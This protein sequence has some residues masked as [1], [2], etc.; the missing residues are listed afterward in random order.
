MIAAAKFPDKKCP[1]GTFTLNADI[2]EERKAS[3]MVI[4]V[5]G[6]G[7]ECKLQHEAVVIVSSR[8][9]LEKITP[10]PGNH[11]TVQYQIKGQKRWFFLM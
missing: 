4:A 8:G 7:Q 1:G 3:L 11:F 5:K 9:H 10:W 6:Y 2:T